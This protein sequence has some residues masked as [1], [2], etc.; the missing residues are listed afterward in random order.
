MT[1]RSYPDRDRALRELAR[2]EPAPTHEVFA[3]AHGVIGEEHV[4]PGQSLAV[5]VARIEEGVRR[6]VELAA[7]GIGEAVARQRLSTQN[8]SL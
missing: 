5:A 6:A 2:K 3:M 7:T 8:P 4:F 1:Y